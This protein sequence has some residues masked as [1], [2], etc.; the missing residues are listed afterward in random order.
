MSGS[1]G[2]QAT[3]VDKGIRMKIKRKSPP[4][5][6]TADAGSSPA[7]DVINGNPGMTSS[8]ESK[9]KR[10][11]STKIGVDG[12]RNGTVNAHALRTA[13]SRLPKRKRPPLNRIVDTGSRD[14][15]ASMSSMC[16]NGSD[17]GNTK[18]LC[19][20]PTVAGSPSSAT[21]DGMSLNVGQPNLATLCQVIFLL[22]YSS[23]CRHHCL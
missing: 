6:Q 2:H 13:G 8:C 22:T 21:V 10:L 19:R 3:I 1:S 12:L 9:R 23:Y 7:D 11:K 14:H 15:A 18:T 16:I 4:T 17:V 5:E 20:D